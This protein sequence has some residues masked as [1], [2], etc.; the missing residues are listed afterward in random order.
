MEPNTKLRVEILILKEAAN[1]AQT[2]IGTA[3][4]PNK[5]GEIPKPVLTKIDNSLMSL[6]IL[7]GKRGTFTHI[8]GTENWL[9]ENTLAKMIKKKTW[10]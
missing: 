8:M 3:T 4:Y 10:Q 1:R 6:M 5:S 2:E 7:P 9:V